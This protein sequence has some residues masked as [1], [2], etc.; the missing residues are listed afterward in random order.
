MIADALISGH[1]LLADWLFVFAAVLFICEAVAPVVVDRTDRTDTR[2][3]IG[4]GILLAAGLA[5]LA[6]AWLV[7]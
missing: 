4:R 6:V 2:R 1:V 3:S 7:L 5:L